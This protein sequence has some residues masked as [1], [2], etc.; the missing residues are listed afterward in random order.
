[1]DWHLGNLIP[2]MRRR[3]GMNKPVASSGAAYDP[4]GDP[5][6]AR[7]LNEAQRHVAEKIGTMTHGFAAPRNAGWFFRRRTLSVD[8]DGYATLPRDVGKLIGFKDSANVLHHLHKEGHGDYRH[9]HWRLELPR[10]WFREHANRT[11]H[12]EY[13]S[14]LAWALIHGT[15]TGGSST[16]L[17]ANDAGMSYDL[18]LVR[19]DD[20]YNGLTLKIVSG[21]GAG[22]RREI[23]D[24]DAD[25]GTFTVSTAW[26]TDPD[27][28]SVFATLLELPEA[29]FIIFLEWALLKL[30]QGSEVGRRPF[31]IEAGYKEMRDAA[32]TKEGYQ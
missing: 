8:S 6:L 14:N 7:Y 22:Q 16:T 20:H 13:N 9:G 17:T 31:D 12:V 11:V 28:T 1:M 15:A 30:P 27:T 3:G 26:A 18:E 23:S 19:S 29:A 25:T 4:T 2:E 21:T 5:Q 24:Y 32:F 10:V